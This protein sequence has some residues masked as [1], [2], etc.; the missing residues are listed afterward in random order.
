MER[1]ILGALYL[2][3]QHIFDLFTVSE[4][5]TDF[6]SVNYKDDFSDELGTLKSVQVD[7]PANPDVKPKY[8]RVLLV[9]YSIK[10]KRESE[11]VRTVKLGICKPVNSAD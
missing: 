6:E 11:L 10:D 9:L 2:N 3:W 8:F 4:D 1:A 5:C 7:I